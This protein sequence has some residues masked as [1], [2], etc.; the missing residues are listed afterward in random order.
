M[1]FFMTI[2]SFLYFIYI[3]LSEDTV[4]SADAVGGDPGGKVL[5]MIMAL[6]LFFGF[7]FITIKERPEQT[8]QDPEANKLRL[9]TLACAILYVAL[10]QPVGFIIVSSLL[11]YS[12]EYIYTTIDK[13]HNL[14]QGVIGGAIT[15]GC[16]S[17]FFLL[18][19]TITK[20]LMSLSRSSVL[21][22]IFQLSTLQAG[23]SLLFVAIITVV[24]HKTVCKKLTSMGQKEISNAS[25]ITVSTVLFLYVVFKQ[26]FNV[27]LSA[28]ILNY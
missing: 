25:V 11:L 15:V 14:K 22:E 16:T 20:Q 26:F 3:F 1:P 13:E 6:F 24:Y 9:I 21:P 8:K 2:V 7:L 28:G 27:N 5:P 10:I 12:L 23:I 18:M 4:L 19:R 17:G